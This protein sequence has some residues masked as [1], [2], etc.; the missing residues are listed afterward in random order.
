MPA[1]SFRLVLLL[2]LERG[3]LRASDTQRFFIYSISIWGL[4][5]SSFGVVDFQNNGIENNSSLSPWI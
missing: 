4:M 5:H 3:G 1:F 2:L